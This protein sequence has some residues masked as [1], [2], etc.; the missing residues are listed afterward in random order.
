MTKPS[1]FFC[2][3]NNTRSMIGAGSSWCIPRVRVFITPYVLEIWGLGRRIIIYFSNIKCWP[4]KYGSS[5][6][7]NRGKIIRRDLDSTM[8]LGAKC[9]F[10]SEFLTH[11]YKC[12]CVCVCVC[13]CGCVYMYTQDPSYTHIWDDHMPVYIF[14]HTSQKYHISGLG[15]CSGSMNF[16]IK[17]CK[18]DQ[19]SYQI[20]KCRAVDK[21]HLW[22]G[23]LGSFSAF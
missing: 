12:V 9:I 5:L 21:F 23:L 18:W 7:K 20:S 11:V 2:S 10:V 14:W 16:Y 13:V 8:L 3:S 22:H 4:S 1:R 19:N 17:P 6:V 15:V